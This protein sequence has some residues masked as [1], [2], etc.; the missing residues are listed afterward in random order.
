M[1]GESQVV[2]KRS[3]HSNNRRVTLP[4]N[5]DIPD[6]N[7]L[8]AEKGQWILPELTAAAGL[9]FADIDTNAAAAIAKIKQEATD[10]KVKI[11]KT[12][13]DARA[14]SPV[15]LVRKYWHE[16]RNTMFLHFLGDRTKVGDQG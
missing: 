2:E 10:K 15:K 8:A 13:A 7:K 4:D 11:A 1:T 6:G 14:M 3:D 16:D 9:A 5:Q 12:L